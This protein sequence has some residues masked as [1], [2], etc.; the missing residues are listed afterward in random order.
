MAEREAD[1]ARCAALLRAELAQSQSV[2]A[3][4]VA[5][6][7]VQAALLPFPLLQ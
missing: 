7:Q 1:G 3:Q 5:E 6:L 4:H 2:G